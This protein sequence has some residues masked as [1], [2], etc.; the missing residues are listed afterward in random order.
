MN[1]AATILLGAVAFNGLCLAAPYDVSVQKVSNYD[2][3]GTGWDS[4]YVMQNSLVTLA[5]APKI[6]GRI[7]QFNLAAFMSLYID[8]TDKGVVPTSDILL[9]GYRTMVSPQSSFPWPP[10]PFLDWKP[11]SCTVTAASADSCALHLESQVETT[12]GYPTLD[13]LQYKRTVTLYAAS[14]HVRVATTLVNMGTATLGPHGIWDDAECVCKTLGIADTAHMW[15]YFPLNPTST[16]GKGRGY[17]Q[18]QN[19]DTTQW[20]RNIAPGIMGVQYKKKAG[21]IGADSKAGWICYVNRL[22][23]HAYVKTFTVVAGATYPDSGSTV[24]VYTDPG[25]PFLEDEVMGPLATLAPNDSILFNEEWYSARTFGPVLAVSPVGLTTHA[26]ALSQSN[27]SATL[28]GTWGVFYAGSVKLLFKNAAGGALAVADSFAVSP[29]DSF[30]LNDR[31][32]VPANAAS[33]QLALYNAAGTLAGTLDSASVTP[34]GVGAPVR[35]A[36][37][38][39]DPVVVTALGRSLSIRVTAKGTW[40]IVLCRPDGR[41]IAGLSCARPGNYSLPIASQGVYLLDIRSPASV[42]GRRIF[43]P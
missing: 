1:R 15:V 30:V 43:I 17:A 26:L 4:E 10:S 6:G 32:R 31:V 29:V 21:K 11:Y 18:L 36:T 20:K 23:G 28:T 7:M 8:S 33:L 42:A 25:S 13:G 41:R 40:S 34:T 2:S 27:D 9:G 22:D 3:W 35:A 37:M 39:A 38:V 19:S 16:M 14:S 5:V 12:S 24:E